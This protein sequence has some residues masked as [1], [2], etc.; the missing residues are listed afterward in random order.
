[1]LLRQRCCVH[2]TLGQFGNPNGRRKFTGGPIKPDYAGPRGE[3]L[4]LSAGRN[5]V[6]NDYV[7]HDLIYIIVHLLWHPEGTSFQ[8]WYSLPLERNFCAA[9][10]KQTHEGQEWAFP[11]GP[12]RWGLGHMGPRS[13]YSVMPLWLC[14][15]ASQVHVSFCLF[16]KNAN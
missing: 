7:G 16:K 6:F 9:I 15:I 12:V 1:M 3:A 4:F 14:E 10:T 2:L 13:G 11:W 5:F 8:Y